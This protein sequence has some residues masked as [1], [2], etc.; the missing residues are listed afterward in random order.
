MVDLC[1][2]AVNQK[3]RWRCIWN[4]F[5]LLC[6]S[7]CN[8]RTNFDW[9]WNMFCGFCCESSQNMPHCQINEF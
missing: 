6:I 1:F 7:K 3:E 8:E 9:V 4:A 2:T 5:Y